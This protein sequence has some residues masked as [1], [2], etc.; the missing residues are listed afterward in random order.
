MGEKFKVSGER[1]TVAKKLLDKH[2]KRSTGSYGDAHECR[3][4]HSD[5][6][7]LSCHLSKWE[8]NHSGKV[9]V[10]KLIDFQGSGKYVVVIRMYTESESMQTGA[11]TSQWGY[12]AVAC[13]SYEKAISMWEFIDDY[14]LKDYGRYYY[15][16]MH[17][18]IIELPR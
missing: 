7:L 1:P 6:G 13:P 11:D 5:K 9:Q 14:G 2:W 4:K 8:K 3:V 17:P 10:S 18:I 16:E 15:Y 12:L